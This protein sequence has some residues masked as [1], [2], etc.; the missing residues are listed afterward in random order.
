M[1]LLEPPA[2]IEPATLP[3]EPGWP[4]LRQ[5]SFLYTVDLEEPP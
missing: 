1:G 2:G 3:T 5:H 4:W